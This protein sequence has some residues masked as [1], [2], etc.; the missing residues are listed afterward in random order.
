MTRRPFRRQ[1][2]DERRA[3]LVAAT[4][5]CIAEHGM[6]GAS[7][8]EI[9]AQAGVSNGLIRHYFADKDSMVREAYRA[10][11]EEMTVMAREAATASSGSPRERLRLFVV[12]NLTPPVLDAKR[13][14]LWAGF[15]GIVH[16]DDRM[17]AIHDEAYAG[18]RAEVEQ[19]VR[20]VFAE[21][22]R[23]GDAAR[24]AI[25]INAL[26]DG[27]WLEGSLAPDLFADSSLGEMGVE[28]VE[29]ILDL[30]L[31]QPAKRT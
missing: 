14:T 15:I 7:V 5:E 29:A 31:S 25:K 21:A 9:A 22:G 13:L 18:F 8:R 23:T 19:M 16:Q 17:A 3:A 1:S 30:P 6:H 27:L 4:I 11:M 10:T 26:I 28:S 2:G 12:A 20:E 24:S